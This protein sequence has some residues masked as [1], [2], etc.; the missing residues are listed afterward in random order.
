[1]S[2]RPEVGPR[3][4]PSSLFGSIRAAPLTVWLAAICFAS[5]AILSAL[6]EAEP[7]LQL[8]IALALSALFAVSVIRRNPYGRILVWLL[9][10]WQLVDHFMMGVR[11]DDVLENAARALDAAVVVLLLLPPSSAW[12]N[13][14]WRPRRRSAD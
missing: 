1:M 9:C 8:G 10:A 13:Q 12:F 7:W 6:A 14:A 3:D 11:F 5:A 4:M 2:E